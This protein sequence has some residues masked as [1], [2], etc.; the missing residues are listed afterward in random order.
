MG[1]KF[2]N[3]S[4]QSPAVCIEAHDVERVRR[5]LGN[6]RALGDE[7]GKLLGA[8]LGQRWD[9]RPREKAR[10]VGEFKELLQSMKGT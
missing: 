2:K 7:L 8:A 5:V 10:L 1:D 6:D 3:A 9:M 4:A